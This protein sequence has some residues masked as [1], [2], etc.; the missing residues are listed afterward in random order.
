MR[1]VSASP[2][3]YPICVGL[4]RRSAM[5]PS[6]ADPRNDRDG[7]HQQGQHRRQRD[8]ALGIAA[9]SDDRQDRRRDH[10]TQGGIRAQHEDSRRPERRVADQAE[11]RRVQPGDRRQAG[12]LGVGHPLRHQ[13]RG[14]HEAGDDVAPQPRPAIGREHPGT[15]ASQL[16]GFTTVDQ[17]QLDGRYPREPSPA[18]LPDEDPLQ[19][20]TS[21]STAAKEGGD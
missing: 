9:G 19:R 10:R 2:F 4:E 16:S 13:Q 6:F 3:M 12:K 11:D 21:S 14:Q 5:N 20:P 1:I 15:T 18:V 7:A 8:R 17:G